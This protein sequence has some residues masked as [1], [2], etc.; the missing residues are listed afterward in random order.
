MYLEYKIQVK[1]QANE[2]SSHF[3]GLEGKKYD[4]SAY[5]NITS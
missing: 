1:T 3:Q 2:C 5:A 4:H